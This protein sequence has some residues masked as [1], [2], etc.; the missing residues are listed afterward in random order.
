MKIKWSGIGITDGRGKI[1]GT[2]AG[3]GRYGAW[4]RRLVTPSNPSTV[5]QQLVRSFM[6]AISQSWKGLTQ[7]QRDLW[8]QVTSSYQ[9]ANI[10]GDTFKYS[11]F[12]LRMKLCRN[13][14]EIGEAQIDDAPIPEAPDAMLSLSLDVDIFGPKFE[15]AFTD[16]ID[17]ADKVIVYATAPQSAGKNFVKSEYRKVH[18][19]DSTDTTPVDIITEYSAVFGSLGPVGGKIFV[20]CRP[21]KIANGNPGTTLGASTFVVDTTP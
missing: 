1:G 4:V 12:N 10:F 17:A 15:L 5:A 2:V 21:I 13:L 14:L 7:V 8:N 18:V 3:K 9:A 11:G 20:Q 6:A 19:M 16:P